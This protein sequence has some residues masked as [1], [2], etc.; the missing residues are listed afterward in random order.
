[1]SSERRHRPQ[2]AGLIW[3]K[4]VNTSYYAASQLVRNVDVATP[5][6]VSAII[7]QSDRH[8]VSIVKHAESVQYKR[9]EN[10]MP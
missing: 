6:H 5:L 9:I 7:C 4:P 1:M 2:H 8:F 3:L 10:L